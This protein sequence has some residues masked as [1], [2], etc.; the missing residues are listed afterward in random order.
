MQMLYTEGGYHVVLD[1]IQM[2]APDPTDA[3][4]PDSAPIQVVTIS[5][6]V[7]KAP[8]AAVRAALAKQ[9]AGVAQ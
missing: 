9:A 6:Y 4:V 8:C 2:F 7:T 5:G 1:H 3:K